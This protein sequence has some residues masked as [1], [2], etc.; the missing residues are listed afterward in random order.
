MSKKLGNLVK[1]ARTAKGLTQAALADK[2]GGITAADVSKIERGEKEPTQEILKKMAKVLGVTQKSL[3]DA[4][5]GSGA[6]ASSSAKTSGSGKTTAKK[7][8]SSTS[9]SSKTLTLTATEKKL[10]ELYRKADSSTKKAAMNLL[11][12]EG[13][14]LELFGTLLTGKN[15]V[16]SMAGDLLGSLLSGKGSGTTKGPVIP[17]EDNEEESRN[18]QGE[19]PEGQGS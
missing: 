19:S 13:N 8:T 15:D 14:A 6:K 7:K 18:S 4:A 17:E 1:E 11:K 5:A 9:S 2:V 12:G 16:S 10:V 3:L